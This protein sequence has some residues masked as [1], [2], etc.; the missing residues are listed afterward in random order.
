L[1]FCALHIEFDSVKS[2][3]YAFDSRGMP[4]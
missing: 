3:E 1:H 4:P 2:A